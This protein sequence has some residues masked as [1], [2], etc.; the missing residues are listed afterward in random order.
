MA[1]IARETKGESGDR[2][3]GSTLSAGEYT[4]TL[5]K[6][7]QRVQLLLLCIAMEFLKGIFS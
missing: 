6:G 5:W 1:G 4:A 7:L 2:G 3:F